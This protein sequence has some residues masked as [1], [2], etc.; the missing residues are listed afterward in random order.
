MEIF[1]YSLVAMEILTVK[2][3]LLNTRFGENQAVSEVLFS[4]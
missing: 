2:S 3:T 4:F 1:L